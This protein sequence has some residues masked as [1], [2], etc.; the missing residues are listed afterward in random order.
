[1]VGGGWCLGGPQAG[2]VERA[3][4]CHDTACRKQLLCAGMK[5]PSWA[6]ASETGVPAGRSALI[7]E[8][9]RAVL[10]STRA[11]A[12]CMVVRRAGAAAC[13]QAGA[14]GRSDGQV[15]GTAPD[16]NMA[17]QSIGRGRR[18]LC[19]IVDDKTILRPGA[20]VAIL[21]ALR[22]R[23]WR[24]PGQGLRTCLIAAIAAV[25]AIGFAQPWGSDHPASSRAMTKRH[26]GR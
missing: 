17:M 16:A 10:T 18:R 15:R 8:W 21:A 4:R 25:Q 9:D 5:L 24:C 20:S 2:Q 22:P 12:L 7:G 23:P 19:S 6:R 26:R 14:T 13:P 3:P 1:V 11:C